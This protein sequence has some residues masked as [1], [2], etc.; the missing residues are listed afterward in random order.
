MLAL[1]GKKKYII[2]VVGQQMLVSLPREADKDMQPMI[3]SIDLGT[4]LD[5]AGFLNRQ[6][7]AN[8]FMDFSN[9][10]QITGLGRSEEESKEPV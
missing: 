3:P 8:F 5:N 9:N 10:E 7:P 6:Y 2:K 1:K 4:I